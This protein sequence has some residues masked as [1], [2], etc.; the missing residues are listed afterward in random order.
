MPQSKSLRVIIDTNIFISFLIGKELTGLKDMLVEGEV[1][2][3]LS[4]ELLNEIKSVTQREKLAKYF[5]IE[6]V[7]ELLELLIIIGKKV[8]VKSKVN[9][10]RDISDNFLLALAKDSKAD[11]LI[12]GDK[13]LLTIKTFRK[14]KIISYRDFSKIVKLN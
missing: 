12:T 4:E 3:I 9:I 10:S 5:S 14:T 11:Y 2:L 13:D 7:N 8:N 1:I 6:K